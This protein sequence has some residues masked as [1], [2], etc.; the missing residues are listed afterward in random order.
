MPL[1]YGT[2]PGDFSTE[3]EE[4]ELDSDDTENE[5]G[6]LNTVMEEV[7]ESSPI[8]RRSS[9]RRRPPYPCHL[10]DCEIREGVDEK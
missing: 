1:L 10:C 2:E 9:H 7:R 6:P 5:R 3:L 8:L 4:A